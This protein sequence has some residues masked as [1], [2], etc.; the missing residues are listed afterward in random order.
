[1]QAIKRRK[2]G[3]HH[4]NSGN[5]S[6]GTT[7]TAVI[8]EVPIFKHDTIHLKLR[9][10]TN[11]VKESAKEIAKKYAPYDIDY[12][13]HA[14]NRQR[15]VNVL[16]KDYKVKSGVVVIKGGEE[17][18]RHCTDHEEIF[19]QEAF[20][21]HLFGAREPGL[22]G[23]IYINDVD[24]VKSSGEQKDDETQKQ[25]D[26][27]TVLYYPHQD[28]THAIF[29]GK[30]PPL[31]HF[32]KKYGV[33]E[34][35]VIE[36]T[37]EKDLINTKPTPDNHIYVLQGVNTDSGNTSEPFK[38][39][40]IENYE[41]EKTILHKVLCDLRRIK[42]EKELRLL[43]HVNELTCRA[44]LAVM[45]NCVPGLREYQL[46]S[47]FQ[48][49]GYFNGGCRHTSYTSICGCGPNASTLHY[50]HAAAPNE[51]IIADGD[52]CLLDMGAEFHC[53]GGDV[54]S[55]FPANG[56][57]TDQQKFIFNTV[58]QAQ[59][60]VFQAMRPGV[61][62]RECH[63]IANRVICRRLF[64]YGLLIDPKGKTPT[65]GGSAET[66]ATAG[67]TNRS[68]ED[69]LDEVTSPEINLGGY[70]MPHGLGH[71]MG[72][73]TH[74]VGGIDPTRPREKKLLGL[75]SLRLN[76]DLAENMVLTVEPGCYFIDF[77]MDELMSNPATQAYVNA[78][79]LK[80]FRGFGGIR[81]ED[82]V[83]VV[84]DGIDNLTR[85]PRTVEEV[86]KVMNGT[87]TDLSQL[88][89]PYYRQIVGCNN[90]GEKRLEEET[91]N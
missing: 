59:E 85:Q 67:S 47:I 17:Q 63:K 79:V 83:V 33:D 75:R 37:L 7:T 18:T 8:E 20:F 69:Y 2:S 30:L 84:K 6:S 62:Y 74:D 46:E 44:H 1:M 49:Y 88:H 66:L 65:T 14:E 25:Q 57:F 90:N 58:A 23:A 45:A 22:V 81:L 38:V 24:L 61:D 56:K 35:R 52:I 64:E 3:H 41:S 34:C 5:S 51:R 32:E 15:L 43:R 28:K 91:K 4:Q 73:D 29:M 70:F 26:F 82:D 76:H 50:G 68:I 89:T 60:A 53:Y 12:S 71:L 16:R 21:H 87:I 78:D 80:T 31:E 42:T 40:G 9:A 36:K 77:L 39:T 11:K 27:K 86:E 72:I 55:S 48:H 54:T 10:T 19:R 13:M